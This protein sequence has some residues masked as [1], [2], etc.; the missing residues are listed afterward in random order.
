MPVS[1]PIALSPLP[2]LVD[3]LYV[4]PLD[5]PQCGAIRGGMPKLGAS[6]VACAGVA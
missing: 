3:G 1:L 2:A 4:R 6:L 5:M